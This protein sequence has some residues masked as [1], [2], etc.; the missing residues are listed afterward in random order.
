MNIIGW[1]YGQLT[2][3]APLVTALGSSNQ[4]LRNYPNTVDTLPVNNSCFSL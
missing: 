4:I 2:G 1:I 3:Y